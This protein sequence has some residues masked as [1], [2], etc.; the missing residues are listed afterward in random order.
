MM[1]RLFLLV[2]LLLA[3]PALADAVLPR[4][5]PLPVLA[6]DGSLSG[7]ADIPFGTK[8]TILSQE[9]AALT[10]QA[11]GGQPLRVR[12]TDVIAAP[13]TG[14]TLMPSVQ[15][16]G[17]T[18]DRPD[19][20]LWDSA[21]QLRAFL[22][23]AGSGKL[24]PSMMIPAASDLAKTHLPV[25]S[26]DKAETSVGTP[27][28]MVQALFPLLL[29][30]LD[31]AGQ[32]QRHKLVLHVLVDGSDYARPFMLATLRQL[33]H[34]LAE[35]PT[36]L[37]E[38]VHFTREVL[39]D[40]GALRDDGEVSASGLRAEW[41]ATVDTKKK[42]GITA[43]L[44]AAL[45]GLAK[46]IDPA[47]TAT[48]LVLILSG[49]GLSDD[50]SALK[51]ATAAGTR[52]AALRTKGAAIGGI[53]L[54]QGTPEP[55]PANAAVLAAL[56]GGAQ[57]KL[58]DFGADLLSGLTALSAAKTQDP[59]DSLVKTICAD[60]VAGGIP[61]LIPANST[62][63]PETSGALAA[64]DHTIWV[65]LPLWLVSESAPL[66]LVPDGSV[67]ADA[68]GNQADI[69]T[70]G[71]IGSVWD[72]ANKACGPA[73]AA[74][75][76]DLSD[77]LTAAQA[78]MLTA[79]Q[80]RDAAR[81][82][83]TQKTSDWQDQKAGLDGQLSSA[84]NDRDAARAALATLQDTVASQ[85]AALAD[86][87][88]AAAAQA[89]QL[90]Q[91]TA[92]AQ[93]VKADL[94]AAQ[95]RAADLS[96]SLDQRNADLQAATAQIATLGQDEDQINTALTAAQTKLA[97][98]EETAASLTQSL[99]DETAAKTAIEAKAAQAQ[100]G[101]Q[102]RLTSAVAHAAELDQTIATLSQSL[103]DAQAAQAAT[104]ASATQAQADLNDRLNAS[105]T[106]SA[107]L[108]AQIA[109]AQT[110]VT[111]LQTAKDDL[112]AR[113]SNAEAAQA[114]AEQGLRDKDAKIAALAA[115]ID[116]LQATVKGSAQQLAD[117]GTTLTNERQKSQTLQ[118]AAAAEKA[119]LDGEIADL[120]KT[121]DVNATLLAQSSTAK[122]KLAA[123]QTQNDAL[124][125]ANAA[126]ITHLKTLS[127]AADKANANLAQVN[128]D[129]ATARQKL[130][131]AQ[132][133]SAA[134]IAALQ[135][136]NVALSTANT[137]ATSKAKEM[138]EAADKA[139]AD[140]AQVSQD[141]A[142]SRQTLETVQ[143]QSTAQIAALQTANDALSAANA[144]AASQV[145]ALSGVSDNSDANLAQVSQDLAAARQKLEKVQSQSAAQIAALQGQ[146][147]DLTK[148][149]GDL[150]DQMAQ[151]TAEKTAQ[152]AALQ[153]ERDAL[154]GQV[155]SLELQ[156]KA[157][158]LAAEAPAV[159][160]DLA[161]TTEPPLVADATTPRPK[162]RPA[163]LMAQVATVAAQT[164]PAKATP[165]VPSRQV[166]PSIK[167]SGL[168]GCKFQWTG[169]AGKLLCP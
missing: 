6:E 83:L 26:I 158:P 151:L 20:Q 103:D 94:L 138:I 134:Q 114:A 128:Q 89:D 146:V 80:E 126:A 62:L 5:G 1:R 139:S 81:D 168:N 3:G 122:A 131:I 41:P 36:V 91:L 50:A 51:S 45:Q 61:C 78:D 124:S 14:L 112:S 43:T 137:A 32:G 4:L 115:Q 140:L 98:L 121:G 56:A 68:H 27:V 21:F 23:G 166:A 116:S 24:L 76:I 72:T 11:E 8:L 96:A 46:G 160:S 15:L 120:S 37:A 10:V 152:V 88:S 136:Q 65:A 144:A 125:A 164:R 60:A 74:Q 42:A 141:L 18:T 127:D 129:L 111:A 92:D 44:A 161:A 55:N 100:A 143:T 59:T 123:L 28:T 57:T 113:L 162:P 48:H 7:T 82:A 101:L 69:R 150:S 63:P 97:T 17:A 132:T 133:Q 149:R 159:T 67:P 64:Q 142:T 119:R 95:N 33:S 163:D 30:A 53:L 49:P 40:S 148:T 165:D 118:A 70:C 157:T 2:A 153:A 52:L 93:T 77:Q 99:E 31:P 117:L 156:V 29:K 85:K 38:D 9:G 16:T 108:Q 106:R 155:S 22:D 147:K 25:L 154:A 54:V 73:V 169:Q 35:Q 104:E 66:D 39:F 13:K 86:A 87:Q 105:E 79:Q 102:D 167:A 58:A 109:Q 71:A 130:D 47:D 135:T 84:E 145:K 12:A 19:L 90:T 34:T 75:G 110:V 107:A